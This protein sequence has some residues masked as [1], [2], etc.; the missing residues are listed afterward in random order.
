MSLA[1]F[2]SIFWWEWGHRFLGRLLGVVFLAPFLILLALKRLPRRLIWRC[3]QLFA[4]GALQ[5]AVGWWMVQSGLEA[6]TSVAPER[7]AAH[8]SLALLLFVG[9]IWTA[10]EAWFG[11]RRLAGQGRSGWIWPSAVF[12]AAVYVQCLLGALVAGN[13]AGL[14]D[15]DWPLMGGRLIPSD[16]WR[17]SLWAT[18]AHGT[19]AVQF[20]HRLWAYALLIAGACMVAASLRHRSRPLRPLIWLIGALLAAQVALG[21]ATLLLTVPFPLA[22][23]HQFTA[24]SI[25]AFATALAWRARRI[26]EVL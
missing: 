22:M 26:L 15:A 10:L 13:H 4:L 9:L 14:V 19:A 8:L 23:L 7:L 21:V 18:V 1:Q 11:Q 17:G 12:A 16:Y 24:V 20:N 3:V 2:K 6:R 5:G 25:L